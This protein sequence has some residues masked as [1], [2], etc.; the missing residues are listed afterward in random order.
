MEKLNFNKEQNSVEDFTENKS[1]SAEDGGGIEKIEKI[2]DIQNKEREF[3]DKIK[4]YA[5][6]AF[7]FTRKIENFKKTLRAVALATILSIPVGEKVFAE[8][9][10]FAKESTVATEQRD[11]EIIK[12]MIKKDA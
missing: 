9:E 1:E 3:L 6:N 12:E 10:E 4:E 2:E 11:Q 5:R 7:H 8:R